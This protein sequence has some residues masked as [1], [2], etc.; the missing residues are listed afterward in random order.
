M[1]E[2]FAVIDFIIEVDEQNFLPGRALSACWEQASGRA[3]V[4]DGNSR[5]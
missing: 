2:R 1:A 4:T 5:G 3:F